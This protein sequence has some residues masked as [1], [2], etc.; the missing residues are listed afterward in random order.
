MVGMRGAD[1]DAR[2][3]FREAQRDQ[4]TQEQAVHLAVS[5]SSDR[6]FRERL[7][8]F[9]ANHFTVSITRGEVVGVAGSFEREVIRRHL[10]GHFADLLVAS[11]RH[12][13]MLAYLDNFRST[14]PDSRAGRRSGKGL[15]ENLARE[16]L[17]LHTLG[18]H[19]GYDQDDVEALASLLTGWSLDIGE[20]GANRVRMA[21]GGA[22]TSSGAYQ[23]HDHRHQPG[24][25]TLLGVRYAQ[26]G[27]EE[28]IAALRDLA[29][30][31]ATAHHV[32]TK[33]VRH[34]VA[35]EPPPAAV[36]RVEQAFVD[37]DGHLP[38]VAEAVIRS[39]EAW[40]EPLSKLKTPRD[41]VVSTAR[42]LGYADQGDAM[43][44]SLRFLG[45]LPYQAPSP[46]GWPD[47][48]AAWLGPEAVLSR[49]EW[50]EE[51][52]RH[53]PTHAEQAGELAQDLLGPVLS[54]RTQRAI[55]RA[56]GTEALTTLLASPEFQRR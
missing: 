39:P 16:V 41:L 11:T 25:K 15:N 18:V 20:G 32:A 36:A 34:F 19:G 1:E 49:V 14:G 29:A 53:T 45:Q 5:A 24:A 4:F 21:L 42:A 38:T 2:K 26:G 43:L 54:R 13:A 51:V 28:G 48:A 10:D 9:W 52:A 23:F 27:E 50:A 47:T 37:S 44:Q 12:P 40:G 56:E 33:L 8:Q 22:P 46:K 35:D 7:V 6:P 3:D 30:H 31:P 55:A 17:E